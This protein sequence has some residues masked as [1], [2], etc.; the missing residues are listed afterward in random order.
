MTSPFPEM[1]ISS[2]VLAVSDTNAPGE[3]M[4]VLTEARSDRT[5][6]IPKGSSTC[7]FSNPSEH[8][9][10]IRPRVVYDNTE[11]IFL[12]EHA[13]PP[14]K[15]VVFKVGNASSCYMSIVQQTWGFVKG[16]FG[17]EVITMPPAAA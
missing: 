8:P 1:K 17:L 16:R 11:V 10:T 7:S 4:K 15:S 9:I 3:W 2:Y 13:I 14:G 6:Y 5:I 12:P